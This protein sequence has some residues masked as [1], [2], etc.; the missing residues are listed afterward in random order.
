MI[1][2]YAVQTLNI[3]ILRTETKRVEKDHVNII[4]KKVG[5]VILISD[6]EEFRVKKV[7]RDREEHYISTDSQSTKKV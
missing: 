3:M 6:K 7:T 5:V 1:Q 4:Q 2:K